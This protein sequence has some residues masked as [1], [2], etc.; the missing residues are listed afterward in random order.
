MKKYSN[1]I[2]IENNYYSMDDDDE[3]EIEENK[4]NS[5]NSP[6]KE[7]LNRY[8]VRILSYNFFLRP[9]PINNNGSDFKNERLKDFI[10]FLP[11]FD[12]ICFQEIFTTLTDRKHQMIRE[13]AKCGFKYHVS[14]KPPSFL[15]EYITDAGLLILSRYEIVECDYYDYYL[16]ISGD[17]P[18]NKGIIFAKIKIN[19]RYLF[20]FNTHL[21]ST[22][23]DESQEN[24]NSTIQVRTKQ[25]EELINFVYN[26]LMSIPSE[27]IEKGLVLIVGDFNIDAHNNQFLREKYKLPKYKIT[28]Y[29]LLK[30]KLSKLGTAID[31]MDK[32]YN[33]H[34]Y[35]YGN[36]DSPEYDQVLTGKAEF[37]MKQTLDYMWEIIPDYELN[38]YNKGFYKLN[39]N[40]ERKQINKIVLDEDKINVLYNSFKVQEFLVKNRPYQQLSDHF[41]ISVELSKPNKNNDLSENYLFN[42]ELNHL[43]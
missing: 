3:N 30:K 28:E 17:A 26:K 41:G 35:T 21:Q 37:N 33:N 19:H 40:S 42:S 22:Y 8:S 5:K 15:S 2:S 1:D 31:I 6:N 34:L 7:L 39:E 23:F 36:N 9:P 14:S 16:N 13:A 18:S 10:E 43:K 38:I 20:L 12:I 24:I 11:E 29:E 32:K 25:T 27:Q 4:N